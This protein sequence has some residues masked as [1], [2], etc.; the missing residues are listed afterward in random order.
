[1]ETDDRGA[2]LLKLAEAIADGTP[3]D[4]ELAGQADP[5]I[6]DSF[7]ALRALEAVIT[8]HGPVP[9]APVGSIG[10]RWGSLQIRAKIGG[11][12]FGEVYRAFDPALE[13]EVALKLLH[14]DQA[15]S[16]RATQRFLEEARRLAK[17][18]HPN[19]LL[20][21]GADV[22]EGRAGMWTDLVRGRT[23]EEIL[24]TDGPMGSREAVP[25]GID[26]CG[27]LAAVHAA[28]MVHRDVKTHNVMREEGGR[29]VLMDFG[30][31]GL[32]SPGAPPQPGEGAYGTPLTVAPEVLRGVPASPATDLYS[33][34]VLLYRLVSRRYPVQASAFAELM[35]K[36][37]RSERT[38]LRE[39]RPDLPADFVQ[40]VE[41]ALDP[42]PRKRFGGAGTMERALAGCMM[43]AAD[44]SSGIL[45]AKAIRSPLRWAYAAAAALAVTA[46]VVMLPKLV[47]SPGGVA[48]PRVSSTAPDS[49][50]ALVA[51]VRLYRERDGVSEPLMPGSGV[52]P[53]DAL[54]LEL[55]ADEP[56]SVYVVNEDEMG[57]VYVLFPLPGLDQ[58]NPLPP[59]AVHRLP[60]TRA[61]Q[62]ENWAVTSA[63][64]SEDVFVIA[65]REPLRQVEIALSKFP[66]AAPGTEVRYRRLSAETFRGIGGTTVAEAAPAPA[67]RPSKLADI[68][69]TLASQPEHARDIWIWQTR[70]S[71]PASSQ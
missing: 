54:Y 6:S 39:A 56:M 68:L 36:H 60:G 42:D 51:S 41:R 45:G 31:V 9:D 52:A 4:W 10:E 17:V 50:P 19:V 22:H 40:V 5:E 3:I 33:L 58:T 21:H 16:E 18:R 49:P 62:R 27:A 37:D 44:R 46:L 61:G 12:S 66:P 1:M 47:P 7:G 32:F 70:L 64:G 20:V 26:L 69:G 53:G 8:A 34:G 57:D 25:I 28:D 59:N 23:L 65:S 71:N 14:T 35:Q 29:I 11:G 15:K 55:A 13:R 24:A 30:S 63:G 38:P 43:P 48:P 67:A 2:R